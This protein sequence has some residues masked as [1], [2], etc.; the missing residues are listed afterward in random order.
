LCVSH[1]ASFS[2]FLTIFQVLPCDFLI[3]L[4]CQFSCHNPTVSISSCPRFLVFSPYSRSYSV[5]FSFFTFFRFFFFFAIVQVLESVF[6]FPR[7]SVFLPYSRSYSVHF[8][9]FTF[10]SVSGPIPGHIPCLCLIFHLLSFL[11]ICQVLQCF[12]LIFHVFQF[13]PN[14]PGRKVCISHFPRFTVF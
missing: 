4:I 7:F 10:I 8:S 6:V 11:A 1:F 2:V 14:I 12:C 3:F 9:L 13:S 5:C